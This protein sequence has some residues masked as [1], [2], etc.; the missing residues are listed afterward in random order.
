[1]SI[2]CEFSYHFYPVGQGLFATGTIR[3]KEN[4]KLG[5]R[6]VYDCGTSSDQDLVGEGIAE[7]T[8]VSG[9]RKRIDLLTLSHFDHDH[10][11]G[12]ASLLREFK[13]GTL[14]LPY[15]SLDQRLVLAFEE[16]RGSQDDPITGFYLNPVAFL[17]EQAGPGIERILF[18]PPSGNVGPSYPSEAP[19]PQNDGPDEG[20]QI[21]FRETER[22]DSED[23][24]HLPQAASE[25]NI[26]VEF[27]QPGSKISLPA[28]LW[29]FIPYN[30][31]PLTA[32]TDEFKKQVSLDRANL[33]SSETP[34]TRNSALMR[35]KKPT[36]LTS[37]HAPRSEISFLCFSI[38]GQFIQ[39]GHNLG[40]PKGYYNLGHQ[41]FGGIDSHL[42]M[43]KNNHGIFVHQFALGVVSSILVMATSTQMP[44]YKGSSNILMNVGCNESASFK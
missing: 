9:D 38:L 42:W 12:V 28:Y 6:W 11:S 41:L 7:L 8:Q 37:A 19:N 18:I 24:E 32:I 23:E 43:K 15:M 17:I 34:D 20:P 14:M 40:L 35:V 27:L 26:S 3:R 5:F 13:I 44:D 29:E 4:D 21:Q 31:D 10:I 33:L 39:A 22:T 25:K 1:M 16:G 36:T 2:K 30:D